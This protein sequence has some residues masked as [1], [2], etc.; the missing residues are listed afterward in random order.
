MLVCPVPITTILI[1]VVGCNDFL[2]I[3]STFLK[4]K[5]IVSSHCNERLK[6]FRQLRRQTQIKTKTP[7]FSFPENTVKHGYRCGAQGKTA[8]GKNAQ[9][10][11]KRETES[12][13]KAGTG[14]HRDLHQAP[15]PTGVAGASANQTQA[16]GNG[17]LRLVFRSI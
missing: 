5:K 13:G 9:A 11:S 16:K 2:V 8:G 15:V 1:Y 17:F 14:A 3:F 10:E 12:A 4:L 6:T 7:D